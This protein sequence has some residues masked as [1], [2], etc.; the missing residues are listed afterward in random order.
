M[1]VCGTGHVRVY[2]FPSWLFH[3]LFNLTSQVQHDN[4]LYFCD[5]RGRPLGKGIAAASLAAILEAR[6]LNVTIM[7]LDPYINVD[8]G[9]IAAQS[10]TGEVFVTED[11]AETDLTGALRAFRQPDRPPQ[12]LHHGSY[13][14]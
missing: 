13:L 2:C 7:K 3:R 1:K 9:T 12:Q 11:G 10:N 8:P 14:L 6:G 4:E 5:R